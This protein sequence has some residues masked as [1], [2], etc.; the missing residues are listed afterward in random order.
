MASRRLEFSRI[1]T[2]SCAVSFADLTCDE[3]SFTLLGEAEI[4]VEVSKLVQLGIG[5]TGSN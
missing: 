1:T 4:L 3:V 2:K 5:G